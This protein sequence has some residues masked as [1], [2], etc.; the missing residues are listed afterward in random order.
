MGA[1]VTVDTVG[2]EE[3]LF[4]LVYFL[5]IP[6]RFFSGGNEVDGVEMEKMIGRQWITMLEKM[7]SPFD[8]LINNILITFQVGSCYQVERHHTTHYELRRQLTSN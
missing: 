4:I 5:S 8:Y 3:K 7:M 2:F 6:S 1:F